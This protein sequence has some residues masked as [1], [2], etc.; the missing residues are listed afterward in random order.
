MNDAVVVE[1]LVRDA[2][3]SFSTELLHANALDTCI[4]RAQAQGVFEVP[5]FV[6][7]EQV[8]IGREH[9]PWLKEIVVKQN[10]S[11]H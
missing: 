6:I 3:L 8:F 4:E 1:Q 10:P 5:A 11:L 9:M 7:D 2:G